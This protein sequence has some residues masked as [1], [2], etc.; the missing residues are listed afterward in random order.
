MDYNALVRQLYGED[1]STEKLILPRIR[2]N[3]KL[4]NSTVNVQSKSFGSSIAENPYRPAVPE[5]Y[6]GKGFGVDTWTVE[7]NLDVIE[8]PSVKLARLKLKRNKIISEKGK[9]EKKLQSIE[10]Q[11]KSVMDSFKQTRIHKSSSSTH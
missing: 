5:E 9:V 1:I 3:K 7:K 11:R 2:E 6:A 4:T 10:E 8:S